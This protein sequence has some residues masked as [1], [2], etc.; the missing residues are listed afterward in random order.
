MVARMS[1][2]I[3]DATGA[4]SRIKTDVSIRT[5]RERREIYGRR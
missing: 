1:L 2:A 3:P 5:A 4:Q